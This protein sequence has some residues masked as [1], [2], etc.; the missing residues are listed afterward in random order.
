MTFDHVNGFASAVAIDS[1]DNVYVVG[2]K[3]RPTNDWWL[4]KF[5]A[6]GNED[7]ANWDKTFDGGSG[8]DQA[9]S[10]VAF[11]PTN[12]PPVADAGSDQT[13]ECTGPDGASVALDASGSS[14]DDGDDLTFTWTENGDEIATSSMPAVSLGLGT[15]T[16][17]LTVGDGTDTDTD[18]V[19]IT[20]EDTTPPEITVAS[21]P[22]VLWPPNHK[23]VTVDINQCVTA[24]S[25]NCN[26]TLSVNDVVITQV[27]SDEPEDAPGNGDGKTTTDIVID[28][29]QTVQIR[30]E[31]QGGGNGRVYTMQIDSGMNHGADGGFHFT[32]SLAN[33]RTMQAGDRLMVTGQIASPRIGVQPVEYV[34]SI[35]D[36]NSFQIHLPDLVVYEI[37]QTT[38]LL[39]NYPNPFNPETWIAYRLAEAANVT[40]TIYAMSGEVVRTI[41]VGHQPAAVYESKQ[42]SIYWDGRSHTG[43]RVASGV[44]FYQ[45]KAGDF[46]ATRKMTILK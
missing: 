8:N 11:S 36:L 20:V 9:F 37:P 2:D 5:D 46:F 13:V 40:L 23:Y 30:R 16:I 42:K 4:K 43:E 26:S 31:R 41:N 38:E 18:E 15:H 17:T 6:S 29:C 33:D 35:N 10:V 24:V 44:Y 21:E 12:Q 14:D 1:F 22:I 19:I 7:T 45:L 27:S 32:I 3:N 28:D 34:V 25:D 39:A